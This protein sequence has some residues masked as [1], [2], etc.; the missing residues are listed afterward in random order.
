MSQEFSQD[1]EGEENVFHSSSS[2]NLLKLDWDVVEKYIESFLNEHMNSWSE[3]DYF[4]IDSSTILIKVYKA[5][6]ASEPTF[7]VK[8]RLEGDKLV[9]VD[10]S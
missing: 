1:K 10:V 9:V 3:Y 5:Y 2:R 6:G 7:S 4:V 8:A